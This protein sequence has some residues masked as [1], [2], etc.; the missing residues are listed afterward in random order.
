MN[1]K[2]SV[3]L[4]IALS[5]T[6]MMACSKNKSNSPDETVRNNSEYTVESVALQ[7]VAIDAKSGQP[8]DGAT[9]SFEGDLASDLTDVSG[10]A[11]KS[12]TLA[13]GAE[14]FY[15][16]GGKT[17]D[18]LLKVK[19]NGYLATAKTVAIAE[20]ENTVSV[21][22]VSLSADIEGVDVVSGTVSAGSDGAVAE[23][24]TFGADVGSADQ[25]VSLSI[26]KGV[27]LTDAA[28]K[29]VTGELQVT[30]A[31]FAP[32]EPT[33]MGAVTSDLVVTTAAG[34]EAVSVV[35][36]FIDLSI[37]SSTGAEVKKLN[38]A[39]K[40]EVKLDPA[41]SD[42]TTGSAFKEGDVLSLWSNSD[43]VVKYEGEA[44]VKAGGVVEISVSHLSAYWVSKDVA[45]C[46]DKAPKLV[47]QNGK[48]VS[49]GLD[50]IA[51][52]GGFSKSRFSEG[53][54]TIILDKF[55][56]SSPDLDFS[57]Y[58]GTE[59]VGTLKAPK[60][61]CGAVVVLPVSLPSY[62]TLTTKVF[63][64]CLQD[65]KVTTPM[66]SAPVS[67]FSANGLFIAGGK[68]DSL[69][70]KKFVLVEGKG[71]TVVAKSRKDAQ[72]DTVS[73]TLKGDQTAEFPFSVKCAEL[74]G[75][76]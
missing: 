21:Q 23:A 49:L 22:L 71:Y 27:V 47:L 1:R 43:G 5:L 16:S 41:V 45:T 55:P 33:A 28:G 4:A 72:A 25:A 44:V 36:A 6:A 29:P 30:M 64:S 58:F 56:A 76:E 15:V 18:L 62:K 34:T 14:S 24:Q 68:T 54:D 67:V 63:E 48:G 19:A 35:A 2:I 46:G 60:V 59:E 39:A 74:T 65:S 53:L 52:A 10:K 70:A 61:G 7:F 11:T 37:A 9:V 69:G 3:S 31:A 8:I 75:A 17:G 42:P 51:S 38:P 57:A 73:L 50:M 66:A 13:G 26:D 40:I 32:S 20:G 12:A